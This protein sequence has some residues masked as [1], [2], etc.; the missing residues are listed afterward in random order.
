MISCILWY[1]PRSVVKCFCVREVLMILLLIMQKNLEKHSEEPNR[2]GCLK[3][4]CNNER[5][6]LENSNDTFVSVYNFH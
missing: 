2:K 4:H 1:N 5:A 6:W 3:Q